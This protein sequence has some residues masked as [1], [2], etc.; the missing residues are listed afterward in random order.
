MIALWANPLARKLIT[1]GA[2]IAAICLCLRWW[3]N[4]QWQKGETAGRMYEAKAIEAAKKKEWAAKEGAIV[5]AAKNLDAE[6]RAVEAAA[7]QIRKDRTDLSRSLADSLAA[8]REERMRQYAH[9][10][11][12]PDDRVWRDIRVMSGQL[13]ADAR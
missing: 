10:A 11:A 3:G 9:A 6:K 8:I 2:V 12:V 4:A 5:I 13:A 7:E 1:Y